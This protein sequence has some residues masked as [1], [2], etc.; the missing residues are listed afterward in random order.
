MMKTPTFPVVTISLLLFLLVGSGIYWCATQGLTNSLESFPMPDVTLVTSGLVKP[1]QL[2]SSDWG[3]MDLCYR[4]RSPGLIP[5][6]LFIQVDA[7]YRYEV[8]LRNTWRMVFDAKR[9][10]AFVII[11]II[12]ARLPVEFQIRQDETVI[13][14]VHIDSKWLWKFEDVDQ[15]KK[16]KALLNSLNTLLAEKAKST[17]YITLRKDEARQIVEAYISEWLI[18]QGRCT[19]KDQP[20]VKVFFEDEKELRL[21]IPSGKKLADFK[22]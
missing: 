5:T 22:P 19:A 21:P 20:I 9:K 1:E 10:V 13:G 8:A 11:P 3:V 12:K 2:S 4:P 14:G 7:T 15:I 17:D 6:W 16:R 18:R